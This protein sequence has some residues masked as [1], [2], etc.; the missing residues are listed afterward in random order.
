MRLTVLDVVGLRSEKAAGVPSSNIRH[1]VCSHENGHQAH[2]S[3]RLML[4][5]VR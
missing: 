1:A 3:A 4:V 2:L 5:V